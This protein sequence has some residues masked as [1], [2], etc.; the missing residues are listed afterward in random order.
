[1]QSEGRG[2][3]ITNRSGR[4][5]FATENAKRYLERYAGPIQREVLPEIVNSWLQARMQ[6]LNGLN[7]N[8][9]LLS[10]GNGQLTIKSLSSNRDEDQRLVLRAQ[11]QEEGG[12]LGKLCKLGL[13]PREAEVLFWVSKGKRNSEIGIILGT[14]SK[15]ITKHLERIFDKLSVETRSAAAGIAI[16]HI[17]RTSSEPDVFNLG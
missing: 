1:M 9:L 12:D 3:V 4:I 7:T 17:N 16:A 2:L 14:R 10:S 6:G 5:R 15:T 11:E 8:D 13:T